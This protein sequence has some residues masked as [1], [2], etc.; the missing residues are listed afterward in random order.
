M[1]RARAGP[2]RARRAQEQQQGDGGEHHVEDGEEQGGGAGGHV[3]GHRVQQLGVDEDGRDH[4]H[5]AAGDQAVEG[6]QQ[7]L[8]AAAPDAG[9]AE[10]AGD[11]EQQRHGDAAVP[12][13]ARGVDGVRAHDRHPDVAGDGHHRGRHQ[14]PPRTPATTD[15]LAGPDAAADGRQDPREEEAETAHGLAQV[16]REGGPEEHGEGRDQG[17]GDRYG[18]GE[19]ASLPGQRRRWCPWAAT[20]SAAG[21][22]HA[23][24]DG[25]ADGPLVPASGTAASGT[26]GRAGPAAPRPRTRWRAGAG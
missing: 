5:R 25:G 1:T 14:Q 13:R 12:D 24:R 9:E 10:Q 3:V 7:L 11:G 17:E 6:H 2:V 22:D 23:G 19:P 18:D 20:L 21:G 4:Q 15:R 16:Q 8:D 26:G